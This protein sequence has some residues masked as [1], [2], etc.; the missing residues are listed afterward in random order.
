MDNLTLDA[1]SLFAIADVIDGYCAKQRETINVY[2]AQ[3][4]ALE[5][6]WRDDET[7]GGIAE[8][9]RTL[10]NKA[11]AILD[12]IYN[13]YPKYFRKKAQ[14]ILERP[15]L[16]GGSSETIRVEEVRVPPNVSSYGSYTSPITRSSFGDSVFPSAKTTITDT[17]KSADTVIH[18]KGTSNNDVKDKKNID[19]TMSAQKIVDNYCSINLQN[20]LSSDKKSIRMQDTIE[21][22]N[23]EDFAKGLGGIER[24]N[25][26]NGY[27]NGKKSYVK[28][29]GSH[30]IKTA[31]HEHNHQLSCN[32]QK[33]KFGY[34][35]EYRRGI[36]INGKDVQINEALTELFTKK[37]MGADYPLNPNVNY[38]DNM[39][40]M[41]K[42]EKTFGC[43]TLKEAYYKNNPEL[44]KNKYDAIM[45]KNAWELLSKAFDDSL[46][47][48]SNEEIVAKR[49]HYRKTGTVLQTETDIK[50]QKATTYANKCVTL[51]TLK[52]KGVI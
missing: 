46:C 8:E 43:E 25:G 18:I 29:S 36:S 37:M 23:D 30:P 44:L 11:V 19:N 15:T 28:N 16:N 45:G 31:I 33:N 49:D 6:E 50:R 27:N 12:E 41:E 10:K 5:S 40:R 1:E 21:F 34:I 39:Y 51:F 13:T 4:M 35:T 20:V 9:I 42:L 48:Y 17:N 3:I 2:Y 14:H 24:A 38:I 7:F 47:K 22:Q 52:A 26:V 32:D